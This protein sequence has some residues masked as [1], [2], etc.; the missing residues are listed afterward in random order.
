M[1]L[2]GRNNKHFKA[3]K[4]LNIIKIKEIKKTSQEAYLSVLHLEGK[5]SWFG[6]FKGSCKGLGKSFNISEAQFPHE[7]GGQAFWHRGAGSLTSCL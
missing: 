4:K 2:C 6:N 1:L 5:K 7:L 3:I